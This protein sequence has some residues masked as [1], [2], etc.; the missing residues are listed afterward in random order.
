MY[1]FAPLVLLFRVYF[2]FACLYA[3]ITSLRRAYFWFVFPSSLW[4]T[5]YFC[6]YIVAR[7]VFVIKLMTDFMHIVMLPLLILC[8]AHA[9]DFCYCRVKLRY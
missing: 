1:D 2:F 9:R 6:V 3:Y 5:F 4:L 8:N 7:K